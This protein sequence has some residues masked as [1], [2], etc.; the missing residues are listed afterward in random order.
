M[1]KY[2][3]LTLFPEVING[4]LDSGILKKAMENNLFEVKCTQIRDFSND[5]HKKTDD[6]SFGGGAGM[7][8]TP[9]PIHDAISV[10][11]PNHNSLRIY[12]SPRDRKSVV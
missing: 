2:D 9:Q 8:M 5:K 7:I 6:Y 4:A 12:M 1:N 10:V 11:D 3:I